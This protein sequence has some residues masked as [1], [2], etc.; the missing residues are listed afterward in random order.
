MF[1]V[2]MKHL[3]QGCTPGKIWT[4]TF[5]CETPL[6]KLLVNN[7]STILDKLFIHFFMY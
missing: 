2:D 7:T 5:S 1:F 6:K 4:V 3:K